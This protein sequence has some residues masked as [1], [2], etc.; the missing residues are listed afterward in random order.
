MVPNSYRWEETTGIAKA[1]KLV[2]EDNES[3]K[4]EGVRN[5]GNHSPPPINKTM[6]RKSL[7]AFGG[8]L[9]THICYC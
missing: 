2:N 5:C 3:L 1:K 6:P 4:H 7:I 8:H 9:N